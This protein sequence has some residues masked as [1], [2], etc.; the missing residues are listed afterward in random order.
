MEGKVGG[1]GGN[2]SWSSKSIVIIVIYIQQQNKIYVLGI[3]IVKNK[4]S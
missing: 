4:K 3:F 2:N 1:H